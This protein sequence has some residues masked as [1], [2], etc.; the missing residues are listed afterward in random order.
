MCNFWSCVLTREGKVFWSKATS[1]HETILQENNL[2]DN[3]LQ[4]RDF[5]RLEV[6]PK[7]KK[8][9]FSKNPENWEFKVDEPKTIPNW[10]TQ[11]KMHWESVVWSE[12]KKAMTQSLWK[13]SLKPVQDFIASIPQVKFFS[14]QGKV[15]ASWKMFYGETWGAAWVA[16]WGAA[17]VAAR[18]A[19]WG[20]AG[21]AAWDAARGAAGGAA[22]IAAWDAAGVA[23][24]VVA[25]DAARDAAGV[26]AGGAAGDA[27]RDADLLARCLL[28]KDRLAKKHLNHAK[29]RWAVWQAGYGLK[30]DVNG[31]LYVYAVRK[32]KAKKERSGEQ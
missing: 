14:M 12:W 27:A 20:A 19:A 32:P 21:V 18:V 29:K 11:E 17:G 8:D 22:G 26:A 6:H 13:L 5:V 3:K 16:A 28:V 4:D 15:S 1:S 2:K 23:A 30:C 25:R 7:T 24:G 9:I 10:F 31:K